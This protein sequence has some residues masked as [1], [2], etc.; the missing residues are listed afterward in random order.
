MNKKRSGKGLVISG[1]RFESSKLKVAGFL[2][3]PLG[4]GNV[5]FCRLS[6]FVR[7]RV[8]ECELRSVKIVNARVCEGE[9]LKTGWERDCE[10]RVRVVRF[11]AREVELGGIKYLRREMLTGVVEGAD[12]RSVAL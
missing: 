8:V 2:K 12:R 11:L 5:F 4:R 7:E 6:V 10:H 3:R 9:I 1:K